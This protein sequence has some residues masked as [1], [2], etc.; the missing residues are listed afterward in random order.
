MQIMED[1]VDFDLDHISLFEEGSTSIPSND[2]VTDI[3][4]SSVPAVG[5]S[6]DNAKDV[7]TF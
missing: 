1:P 7:R 5:M 4:D 2:N 6:F 3:L